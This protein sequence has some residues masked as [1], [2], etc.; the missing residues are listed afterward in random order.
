MTKGSFNLDNPWQVC[1]EV[2]L[3]H[4]SRLY[5]AY[6]INHHRKKKNIWE[7][8]KKR[9]WDSGSEWVQ[10]WGS[11]DERPPVSV[12]LLRHSKMSHSKATYWV[13]DFSS[14]KRHTFFHGP[15]ITYHYP[16]CAHSNICSRVL[17]LWRFGGLVLF[18]KQLLIQLLYS[19]SLH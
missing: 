5:Q 16:P 14:T 15:A 7:G 13:K 17:L 10:W 9:H 11:K 1:L 4:D 19:C 8:P 12:I 2:C 6:N 18:L 3:L